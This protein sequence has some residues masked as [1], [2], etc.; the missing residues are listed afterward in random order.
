MADV[1]VVTDSTCYLP[2]ALADSLGITV[3][4]Q[5]YDLGGGLLLAR[6]L[7]S[8]LVGV[9]PADPLTFAEAIGVM[10]LLAILASLAPVWRAPGADAA[11]PESLDGARRTEAP[12]GPSPSGAPGGPQ[13]RLSGNKSVA[14]EWAQNG[15]AQPSASR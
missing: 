15:D 5:H 14:L 12:A 8:E 11:A 4:S 6:T 2:A 9:T 7:S 10:A 3:V 13:L 1:A